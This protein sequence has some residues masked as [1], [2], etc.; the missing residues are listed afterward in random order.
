MTNYTITSKT[1]TQ[2]TLSAVTINTTYNI[3]NLTAQ[4]ADYIP[5]VYLDLSNMA[6]GDTTIVSEY[7]SVDGTNLKLYY[8]YTFTNAQTLPVQRF[9]GKLLELNMLYRVTLQQTAGTGRAYP[10]SSV[11]QVF[12]A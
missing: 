1:D 4:T 5:E 7:I 11:V 9:H 10:Y 8:Q 6:S 2:S 3:I 12:S